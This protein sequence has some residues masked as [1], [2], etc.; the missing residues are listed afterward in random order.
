MVFE[1][2]FLRLTVPVSFQKNEYLKKVNFLMIF[3][4]S[5]SCNNVV[6]TK[7]I[8]F[9]PMFFKL[10]VHTFDNIAGVVGGPGY[11]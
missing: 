2:N 11:Y 3:P 9:S 6:V 4:Q 10:W 1:E 8:Y 5:I 7:Q